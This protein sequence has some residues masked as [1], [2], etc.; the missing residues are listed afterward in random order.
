MTPPRTGPSTPSPDT[1]FTPEMGAKTDPS[2]RMMLDMI[3]RLESEIG[4][5][6]ENQNGLRENQNVLIENQRGLNETQNVL[7][8][9][10]QRLDATVQDNTKDIKKLKQQTE[11]KHV[12]LV[13]QIHS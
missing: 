3:T 10:K 6:N 2:A 11:L 7:I 9:M 12:T 13:E 4:I 5:S 8:A 1:F